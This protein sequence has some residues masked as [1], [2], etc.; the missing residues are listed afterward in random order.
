MDVNGQ[1]ILEVAAS[2]RIFALT[3]AWDIRDDWTG[4]SS[5]S[6]RKKRQNRINQRAYRQSFRL[7]YL[8]S[9]MGCKRRTLH[10]LLGKR[11]N[12]KQ[13]FPQRSLDDSLTNG[14]HALSSK[15]PMPSDHELSL[16]NFSSKRM[17]PNGPILLKSPHQIA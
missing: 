15:T 6:E 9:P 4:V 16:T 13:H 10:R 12:A 2:G 11:K 7:S 17:L 1:D 5:T 14:P 8:F 3:D